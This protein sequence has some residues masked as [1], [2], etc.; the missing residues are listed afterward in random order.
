MQGDVTPS[1]QFLACSMIL[2]AG[3]VKRLQG[4]L[5]AGV[6]VG[7][8]INGLVASGLAKASLTEAKEGSAGLQRGI[9]MWGNT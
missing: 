3:E 6:C 1:D 5:L 7:F 8:M 4:I 9:F 2:R